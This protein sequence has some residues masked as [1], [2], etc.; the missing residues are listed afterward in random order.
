MVKR[1]TFIGLHLRR[2]PTGT[3]PKC[4]VEVFIENIRIVFGSVVI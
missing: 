1:L 4:K 3:G 2:K